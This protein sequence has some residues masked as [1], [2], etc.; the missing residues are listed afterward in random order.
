MWKIIQYRS[1]LPRYCALAALLVLGW[2]VQ[3]T[4]DET[5]LLK[6]L[7]S[8]ADVQAKSAACQQL[9]REATKDAVPV[10][11]ELLA[12]E[13]L[14]HMARYAMERHRD[15]SVDQALREAL[16]KVQGRP[17]LGVIGSL[18]VRR[19]AKAVEPLA[20]TAAK[21]RYSHGAGRRASTGQYRHSGSRQESRR[22]LEGRD[23]RGPV[24]NL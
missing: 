1:L 22:C 24:S 9:A 21:L 13:K 18:G 3:L 12:D 16:D 23:G 7:R 20:E 8:D 19:D 15:P 4:A 6:V 10:L 2:T 17:R 5:E 14:S 11:A